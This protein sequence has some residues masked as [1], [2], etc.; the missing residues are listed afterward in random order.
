MDQRRAKYWCDSSTQARM[1]LDF[2]K[3]YRVCN[4]FMY[5]GNKMRKPMLKQPQIQTQANNI[6]S[7]NHNQQQKTHA[8]QMDKM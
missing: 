8:Q 2:C 1:G 4:I 5:G 7:A 6:L 3:P